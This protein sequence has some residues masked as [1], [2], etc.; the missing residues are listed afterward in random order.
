[1]CHRG[2]KKEQQIHDDPEVLDRSLPAMVGPK[3]EATP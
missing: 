1:M 3:K 2:P